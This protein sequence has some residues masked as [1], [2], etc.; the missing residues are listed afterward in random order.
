MIQRLQL[1]AMPPVP[2]RV[3]SPAR[4]QNVTLWQRNISKKQYNTRCKN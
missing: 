2:V 4:A 1:V 3:M